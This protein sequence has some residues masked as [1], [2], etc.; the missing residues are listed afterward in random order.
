MRF[1][2]YN[3]NVMTESETPS[4]SAR[5][6]SRGRPRQTAAA[7]ALAAAAPSAPPPPAS[8]WEDTPAGEPLLPDSAPQS[9]IRDSLYELIP[10]GDLELDLIATP[11]FGRLQ[12]VK[13]LGF[14]YRVWPGATHTR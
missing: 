1:R 7:R 3:G 9:A 6:T 8:L 14:V 5:Q 13:Q 2:R 12:G 4:Q 10:L 11:E